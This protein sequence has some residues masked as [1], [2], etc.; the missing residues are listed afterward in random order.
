VTRTF[1]DGHTE[2]W[3]A[4]DATLGWWG[5]DGARRLVVATADPGT[6]PPK[7]TRYLVTSLPAPAAQREAGGPHPAAGLAE[8]VRIYVIPHYGGASLVGTFGDLT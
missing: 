5:P 6:L 3:R 8:I 7:A 1:R 2:T 4:A